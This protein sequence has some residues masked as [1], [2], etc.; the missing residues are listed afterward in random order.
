MLLSS[1]IDRKRE[2]KGSRDISKLNLPPLTKE[3]CND[4]DKFFGDIGEKYLDP[5]Y[6]G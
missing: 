1:I 5:D 4:V 2:S 6:Y 3:R